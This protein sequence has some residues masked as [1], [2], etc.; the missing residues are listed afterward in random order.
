M[1]TWTV[2][3]S[4][5]VCDRAEIK[6]ESRF[7]RHHRLHWHRLYEVVSTVTDSYLQLSKHLY[8]F[9]PSALRSILGSAMKHPK[10]RTETINGIFPKYLL[11]SHVLSVPVLYQNSK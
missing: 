7:S 2:F 9:S 6:N 11:P 3:D 8:S 1:F 10:V 5:M 4:R